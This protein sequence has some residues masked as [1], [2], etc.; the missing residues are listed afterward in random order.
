MR[1]L[2]LR[3]EPDASTPHLIAPPPS[4]G[5]DIAGEGR[6]DL[7]KTGGDMLDGG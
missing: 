1:L 3:I 2:H 6:F 7:A 4:L 5:D